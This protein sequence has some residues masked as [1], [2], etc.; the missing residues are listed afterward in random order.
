M[1][2]YDEHTALV[3]KWRKIRPEFRPTQNQL[4][5]PSY[6][7]GYG[8]IVLNNLTNGWGRQTRDRHNHSHTGLPL[9]FIR[10]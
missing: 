10:D 3:N 7:Q 6:S 1:S 9:Q 8:A 4:F 2:N 5:G